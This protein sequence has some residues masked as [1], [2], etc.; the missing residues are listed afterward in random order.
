MSQHLARMARS[1][2]LHWKRSLLAAIG[3]LVLLI[4]AAGAAGK[5][6]DDYSVP[7]TESQ[8]ALDLFQAHSPEF[9]GVDSTLVFT[10]DNGKISDAGPK[11][12][13]EGALAKVRELKGVEIA[14]SPF[15]EGGQVSRDG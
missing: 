13:I 7:G 15:A 5:A 10:V 6:T 11:A 2:S 8:D 1:I 14:A 3:V 12:A 9:G 4:L